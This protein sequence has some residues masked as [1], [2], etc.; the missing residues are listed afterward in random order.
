MRKLARFARIRSLEEIRTRAAQE[1]SKRLDLARC[2]LGLGFESNELK[3][4]RPPGKTP[5]FFFSSDDVPKISAALREHLT[6]QSTR[7]VSN[8]EQICRG[9]FDLLGFENLNF[10]SPINWHLDP[11]H[12]KCAPRRIWYQVPYLDTAQVGDSKIIWELNRHQ[13]LVTLAKAYC[14]T[15]ENHFVQRILDTWTDWQRENPYPFG[16]NWASSLEVG[17]RSLSWLWV[18]HLLEGSGAGTDK[19]R[20]QLWRSLSVHGR[21]IETYLSTYSS[22]NTHLLGEVVA[23]FFLGVLCPELQRA[24]VWRDKGWQMIKEQSTRQVLLDG[25]HFEQST[26]YHTYALDFLLHARVLAA[27]NGIEIP[28][29]FDDTLKLMLE[30][31]SGVGQC[32]IAPRFGDD[33]GGRVFDGRR[34]RAQHLLDPLCTGAVLF[35]C[36]DWKAVAGALREE[37]IWLLGPQAASEYRNLKNVDAKVLSQCFADSGTYVMAEDDGPRQ[38]LTIDAGRQGAFSSGHG[39]ADALSVHLSIGGREWLADPGTYSYLPGSGNRNAFRGTA[40][41]NTLI[42]DRLDQAVSTGSFS[43]KALPRVTRTSWASTAKFEFWEGQH[44]GY[45]RLPSPV[46]HR[47]SVFHLRPDFWFLH[48]WVLGEGSH[49]L[50]IAWHFAPELVVR[51]QTP[52]GCV[53]ADP[54]GAQLALLAAGEGAGRVERGWYSAVYGS[55]EPALVF[56]YSQTA[57]VPCTMATL[58]IPNFDKLRQFGTLEKVRTSCL[59]SGP[60]SYRYITQEK[61]HQWVFANGG[62]PWQVE[63]LSS[64]AR[65]VYCRFVEGGHLDRLFLSGGTFFRFDQKVLF[66]AREATVAYEWEANTVPS[67]DLGLSDD[68][69]LPSMR[70]PL[71]RSR[72]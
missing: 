55:K 16:I 8:A 62:K 52:S 11:V 32:G 68:S 71:V 40:A 59:A 46:V 28:E 44:D 43:W 18:W 27:R 3:S 15:G 38:Q 26:Y 10:D 14:L 39:H 23:M 69:V 60:Y 58:I 57:V 47:R 20:E 13:H 9:R 35:R 66:E 54:D 12:K 61:I 24:A 5:R 37:T 70:N 53:V 64:D 42:A 63:S 41:H 65:V 45:C 67:G 51:A 1:I 4:E 72:Q 25:M 22:P 2:L 31:L 6:E 56:R 36:P 29:E 50:D 17:F 34:N 49:Q 19:F 33:D 7:I 21:H 30:W 48:D